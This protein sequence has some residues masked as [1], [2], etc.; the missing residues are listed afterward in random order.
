MCKRRGYGTIMA[1]VTAVAIG[2]GAGTATADESGRPATHE[3][4]AEARAIDYRLGDHP[5]SAP[6]PA[7]YTALWI[8]SD[9][10]NRLY[11]LGE[12]A[13]S[14]S[15]APAPAGYTALKIRS[16]ALNRLYGLGESPSGAPP[17]EN[18]R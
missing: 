10:L 2:L 3:T 9:A 17:F 14:P 1:A 8:R 12:Y 6:A 18:V 5:S 7:W 15:S 16:D 4:R 13:K 11:G